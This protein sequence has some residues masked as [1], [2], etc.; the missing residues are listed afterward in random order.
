MRL[1]CLVSTIRY[2][3]DNSSRKSIT[4]R[5]FL[6]FIT[7]GFCAG[8]M[9][10]SEEYKIFLESQFQV[11]SIDEVVVLTLSKIPEDN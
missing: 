2:L 8:A 10:R 5:E 7:Y 1:V 11:V 3:R 9:R 6:R 4:K